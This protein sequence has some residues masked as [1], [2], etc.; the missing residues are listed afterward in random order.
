MRGAVLPTAW[1]VKGH[2]HNFYGCGAFKNDEAVLGVFPFV[3]STFKEI[4]IR[5][6]DFRVNDDKKC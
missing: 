3:P 5:Q 4:V 1:P 6:Y 2:C